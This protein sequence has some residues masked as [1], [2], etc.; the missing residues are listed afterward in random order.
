MFEDC[1]DEYSFIYSLSHFN[2]AE[3]GYT[4]IKKFWQK[5]LGN[6][7]NFESAWRKY[8]SDGI[9]SDFR[10]ETISENSYSFANFTSVYS[11]VTKM[12]EPTENSLDIE[13]S[14]DRTVYDGNYA[15][16]AWMQETQIL[17]I[18]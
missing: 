4:L 9:I 6:P 16:N 7:S 14:L 12:N 1:T 3:T 10:K 13:F 15:N 17:F 18:N 8:L 5:K 2:E 11:K